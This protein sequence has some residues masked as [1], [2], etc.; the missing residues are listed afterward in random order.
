MTIGEEFPGKVPDPFGAIADDDLLVC[1]APAA[2]PGLDVQP[3]AELLGVLD[4][5]GVGG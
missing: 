3:L 2:F 1:A 4:G 5:P